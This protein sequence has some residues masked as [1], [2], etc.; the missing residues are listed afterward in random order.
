MSFARV[1]TLTL[2]GIISSSAVSAQT[3]G[4]F[5]WRTEP[6][7]NV[8]NLTVTQNGATFTLDGFDEQCG[9]NPRLP[10]H[11]IAVPQPNG[12]LTLGLSVVNAPASPLP[13]N[14][15]AVISPAT[16]SGT[17]R[18][19]A[20]G[21]GTFTFSPAG[22]SGGPRPGASSSTALP[23]NFNFLPNGAFA[24]VAGPESDPLPATG[25]GTRLVW[26]AAKAAFRAGKAEGTEWDESNVGF[27]SA[28]FGIRT[29]AGGTGSFAAGID[30]RATGQASV[31]IGQQVSA[32]GT[33]SVV[34]GTNG[35]TVAAASG[36]FVFTD[37]S[38]SNVFNGFTPNQFLVRAH[39]GTVFFTHSSL[40]SGVALT[41]G[42]G[43]WG[44]LSDAK[45]KE[46][47][48]DLG[49]DD[50]LEKLAVMPIREWNYKSQ[51]KSIRHAGPTAQDFH[52]AFGLGEDPLRISTVDA[53]GIAL[54]AIQA[55]EAR[56]READERNRAL[57]RELSA[58]RD[59][60]TQLELL[61]AERR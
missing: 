30:A 40:Q 38:T 19:S 51:D 61:L 27:Y 13:V 52:A 12:T 41:T 1:I 5:R 6:F 4:T 10:V 58:L 29:R 43:A 25:I 9:G 34:L 47:F 20:G 44:T 22:T 26:H 3:L 33:G 14:L 23:T 15:E 18:D 37:S 35:G 56:T 8:L 54:R 17:W 57:D 55:L 16:V 32:A 42:A 36:T 60:L 50:V 39:G 24:A 31:A 53:D 49:G 46:N 45:M 21:S 2:V 7:C 48:R 28:A 11:G 59:R